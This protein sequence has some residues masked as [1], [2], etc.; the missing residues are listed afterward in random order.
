MEIIFLRAVK[1]TDRLI[2]YYIYEDVKEA[3]IIEIKFLFT[4]GDDRDI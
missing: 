1:L 2:S 4:T 3:L